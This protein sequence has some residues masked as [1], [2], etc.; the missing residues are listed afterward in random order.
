VF[1]LDDSGK[2]VGQA[3]RWVIGGS[4]NNPGLPAGA[5]NTFNFVVAV[6]KSLS[7]T[8]LTA[9]VSFSRVVLEG[10]KLAD[11]NKDVQV[12]ARDKNP[13]TK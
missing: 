9:K 3:S 13:P 11:V 5:T 4:K 12:G 1:L 2:M 10:G 8:N 6:D 7:S